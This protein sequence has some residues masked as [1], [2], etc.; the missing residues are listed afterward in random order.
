[1]RTLNI[2]IEKATK[3]IY[4]ELEGRGGEAFARK[5]AM[6]LEGLHPNLFPT[7]EAWL[8]GE[9]REFVYQGISLADI[10]KKQ[11]GTYVNALS[12]MSCIL[13]GLYTPEEYKKLKYEFK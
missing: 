10:M 9:K 4:T 1:M 11:G 13:K 5:M 12:T 2:D 7:I 6:R 3:L 8:N